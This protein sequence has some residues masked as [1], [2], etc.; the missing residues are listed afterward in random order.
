MEVIDFFGRNEA[1]SHLCFA[2]ADMLTARTRGH[3][4]RVADLTRL[5]ASYLV[6][7]YTSAARKKAE[8]RGGL[9][10]R[11]LHQIEDHISER[12]ADENLGRVVN[13]S[14]RTEPAPPLAKAFGVSPASSSKPP[15]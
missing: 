6:E 1:F 9:T 13:Y 14:G 4:R 10:I 7:K 11:Q 8:I 3:T 12:L 2:C 15:G 5:S